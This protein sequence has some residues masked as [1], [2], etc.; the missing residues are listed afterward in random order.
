MAGLVLCT[1][2]QAQQVDVL[3]NQDAAFARLQELIQLELS[4]ADRVKFNSSFLAFGLRDQSFAPCSDPA[5]LGFVPTAYEGRKD[6]LD[7]VIH[8]CSTNIFWAAHTT[9]VLMLLQWTIPPEE[10]QR[11]GDLMRDLALYQRAMSDQVLISNQTVLSMCGEIWAT[12][13]LAR[14]GRIGDCRGNGRPTVYF[15]EAVAWLTGKMRVTMQKQLSGANV[16]APLTVGNFVNLMDQ[17]KQRLSTMS[18]DRVVLHEMGHVV[19]GHHRNPMSNPD[20][21]NAQRERA[22]DNFASRQKVEDEM[23]RL[24]HYSVNAG[25]AVHVG[26]HLALRGITSRLALDRLADTHLACAAIASIRDPMLDQ[27]QTAQISRLRVQLSC[28]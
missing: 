10:Q 9:M 24:L 3:R 7:A 4:T 11:L 16:A 8:V 1:F 17:L 12:Y 18:F 13:F 15:D 19:L 14:Y 2:S 27:A 26:A 28:K 20:I 22:A 21:E 23:D 5:M 6:S 25:L